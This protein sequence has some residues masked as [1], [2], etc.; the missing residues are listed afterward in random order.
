[1][2]NE[3]AILLDQFFAHLKVERGLAD[4]TVTSYSRDLM[5]FVTFLDQEKRTLLN[6]DR[7]ILS[8]YV[9][10]LGKKLSARSVARHVSSLRRFFRFLVREGKLEVNPAR[11][12][13]SPKM[14]RKLPGTLSPQEVERLLCAPKPVSPKGQ[15]D[16]A[17]L[18]LL[19]ATGLRV[20]ELVGLRI[21]SINLESGYVRTLGKGSKERVVPM[22]EKARTALARYLE[23]G[24]TTLSRRTNSA[25]LFL[26]FRGKPLTRQGFWKILKGYAV[27]AGIRKN[28]TPHRLRHSF[29]SHLLE[30]GADLRS[31]Q[32]ML[33]HADI[34]TTQIYTHVTRKR[35]IHLHE[36]CHPRP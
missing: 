13:E 12:L 14:P 35:L 11:L 6:L 16:L 3:T 9:R 15:R 1:M 8:S 34:S 7:E 2:N 26:N 32:M 4:N 21:S 17:M 20:S 10:R 23:E 27:Q 31:V 25:Y 29:A 30:A 5:R 19:Y 24:R 18:E 36:T 33:G 28:I 22:G